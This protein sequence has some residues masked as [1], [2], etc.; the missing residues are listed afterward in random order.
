M[1]DYHVIWEIDIPAE[2]PKEAAEQAFKIQQ[3][4]ETLA[5][6]FSMRDPTG[7]VTEID[8]FDNPE[9][10]L[11]RQN[12]NP[13]SWANVDAVDTETVITLAADL[14]RYASTFDSFTEYVWWIKTLAFEFMDLHRTK[15]DWKG[16]DYWQALTTFEHQALHRLVDRHPEELP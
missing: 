1:I 4:P 12:D 11:V 9:W 7:T 6:I 16:S 14:A 13:P 15:A 8:L 5:T 2:T 3:D 10:E